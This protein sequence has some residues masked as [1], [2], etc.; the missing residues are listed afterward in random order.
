MTNG[1]SLESASKNAS[2][3]AASI[4]V[5]VFIY[6]SPFLLGLKIFPRFTTDNATNILIDNTELLSDIY[7]SVAFCA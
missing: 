3:T 7:E 4:V 2:K 5:Q 1:L 6:P